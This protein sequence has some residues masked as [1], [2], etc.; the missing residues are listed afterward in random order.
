MDN[1]ILFVFVAC[2]IIC[3]VIGAVVGAV[4]EHDLQ[5]APDHTVDAEKVPE[6]DW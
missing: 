1:V 6:D 3:F 4:I 5:D 2:T